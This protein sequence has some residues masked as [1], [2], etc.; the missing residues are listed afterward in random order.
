MPARRYTGRHMARRRAKGGN[1][2]GGISKRS[3]GLYVG[4]VTVGWEVVDGQRKQLRRAVYGRTIADVQAKLIEVQ[5]QHQQG[6]LPTQRGRAKTV[7]GFA[8]EWLAG[9]E[10]HIRPRSLHRYREL[11][12]LHI[13]PAL[14][15]T[16]LTKL[17][18]DQVNRLLA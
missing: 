15:R 13:V 7:A 8:A 2:A 6:A 9:A 11:L 10:K 12:E 17:T 1:G 16:P 14:G 3:D 5:A 18:V 4:R